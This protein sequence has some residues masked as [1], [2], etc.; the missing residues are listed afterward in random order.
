MRLVCRIR[1]R[2]PPMRRVRTAGAGRAGKGK[3]NLGGG[4][5][6]RFAEFGEV[7]QGRLG[8]AVALVD[9]QHLPG[10]GLGIG[11]G[12]VLGLR[13]GC[14]APARFRF[15][16]RLRSLLFSICQPAVLLQD[17]PSP[18]CTQTHCVYRR[19]DRQR[20]RQGAE[21]AWAGGPLQRQRLPAEMQADWTL[22]GGLDDWSHNPLPCQ[23]ASHRLPPATRTAFQRRAS[24]LPCAFV[25][26]HPLLLVPPLGKHHAPVARHR[27]PG[28]AR[29]DRAHMPH[30]AP[31]A[32][33]PRLGQR[34]RACSAPRRAGKVPSR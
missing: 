22:G 26:L 30:R 32:G 23:P 4:R 3:T 1:F 5:R 29:L 28:T 27:M 9:L 16:F 13:L 17:R 34:G 24:V 2:P 21:S 31:H 15:R 14:A 25:L 11:L 33:Q 18:P 10:L 8:V 6:G 20:D 7:F 19:R 12:L